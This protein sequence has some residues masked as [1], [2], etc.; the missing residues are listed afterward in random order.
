MGGGRWAGDGLGGVWVKGVP[1]GSFGWRWEL[2][3]P[4]WNGCDKAVWHGLGWSCVLLWSGAGEG[5]VG[6]D[7]LM[8]RV[9]ERVGIRVIYLRVKEHG[10]CGCLNHYV[11]ERSALVMTPS[12][13]I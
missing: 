8:V 13:D 2:S 1:R 9:R 7:E 6:V 3:H 11:V 12:R 4:D 5:E 10:C